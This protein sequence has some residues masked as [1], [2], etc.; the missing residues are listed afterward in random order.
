MP[1]YLGAMLF[2]IYSSALQRNKDME[3]AYPDSE[4]LW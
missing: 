4:A 3:S 1:S 2:G